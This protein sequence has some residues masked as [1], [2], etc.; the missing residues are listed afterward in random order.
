MHWEVGGMEVEWRLHCTR[1]PGR[2]CRSSVLAA[3]WGSP[4]SLDIQLRV[5]PF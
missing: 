4:G 1:W 2:M 5:I 3:A